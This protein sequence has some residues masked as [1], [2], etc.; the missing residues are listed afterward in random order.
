[1][2]GTELTPWVGAVVWLVVGLLLG[3]LFTVSLC[4][5]AV[6]RSLARVV[7]VVFLSAG[8]GMGIWAAVSVVRGDPLR[9]LFGL[10]IVTEV[11]EAF[12]W[13]G[14]LLFAGLL[15]LILSYAGDRGRRVSPL[16]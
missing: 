2:S 11:S 8:A 7:A 4:L 10:D 3:S 16:D 5:P 14:G 15:T 1:M 6:G 13:G 9:P 12:A